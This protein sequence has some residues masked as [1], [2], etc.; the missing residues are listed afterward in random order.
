MPNN[1]LDRAVAITCAAGLA[2]V[3]P[4]SVLLFAQWPLREL[5]HSYSREANDMAQ[6][7]F[8][9]YVSIAVAYATRTRSHLAADWFAR[10]YAT[11][12][13]VRLDRAAAALIMLPW[14]AFML[15]AAAPMVWQSVTQLER[16]AET[17]NPGYFLVKLAVAILA[18]LTLLQAV[19]TLTRRVPG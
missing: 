4:L 13:Q 14:S 3:L 2:L 15:Y 16:F 8:A 5:V 1:L 19:D 10:R 7:L 9:L 12:T 18:L 17:F 11:K 6:W